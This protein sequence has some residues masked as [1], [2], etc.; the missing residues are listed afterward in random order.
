MIKAVTF[1]LWGTLI[2]NSSQYERE[3]ARKREDLLFASLGGQISRENIRAAMEY[4][5]SGIEKMRETMRDV[6]TSEHIRLLKAFLKI[7]S[8]LEPAYAEA[9]LHFMP[10]LNPYSLEV[11]TRVK[12]V[13]KVG[14]ISNTGITPGRVL[15]K[16]LSDLGIWSLFD[17][18]LFSNEVGYLKPHPRI[19]EDAS[20][21][22]GV[23]FDE[24]L[25]VGDDRVAD[26]EGAS[27]VG[28]NAILV[29]DPGDLLH[30]LD[31]V[32]NGGHEHV[33]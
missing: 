14:L 30:V 9:V 31:V 15:R 29:E 16:A 4:A 17:V 32:P 5:Q 6:P 23:S 2:L 8:N 3:L 24:M 26:I 1:D 28:M 18:G 22:L 13:A 11:L 33:R 27:G 20:R 12:S 25:H 21:K 19:F 7:D 10:A